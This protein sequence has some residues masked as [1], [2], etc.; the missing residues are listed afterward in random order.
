V[1]HN[2]AGVVIFVAICVTLIVRRREVARR[3]VAGD[4]LFRARLR[5]QDVDGDDVPELDEAQVARTERH[6]LIFAS[7]LLVISVPYFADQIMRS[8]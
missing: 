2:I 6:F 4:S 8:R 7:L 5:G 1:L 3:I